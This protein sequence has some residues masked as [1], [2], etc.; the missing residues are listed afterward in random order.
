MFKQGV[1]PKALVEIK[2]DWSE[3]SFFVQEKA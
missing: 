3:R 2:K 1:A